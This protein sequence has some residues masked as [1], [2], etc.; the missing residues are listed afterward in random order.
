M[1]TP[2]STARCVPNLAGIGPALPAFA[3][4][5]VGRFLAGLTP[6]T[7]IRGTPYRRHGRRHLTA[8]DLRER[9]NDGLPETSEEVPWPPPATA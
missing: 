7:S 5:D 3:G 9:V 1:Q 6:A 2:T 8:A 4:I